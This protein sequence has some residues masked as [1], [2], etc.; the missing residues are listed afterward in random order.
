MGPTKGKPMRRKLLLLS[1]VILAGTSAP[2]LVSPAR[3]YF[4]D[5]DEL[6][7]H[8][9]TNIPDEQFDPAVCVTY[10]MGAY[11]AYM[12]QRLVRNQPRCT[13]RTLTAGQLRAVVVDYLEDNPDNRAMDA[14]ALVWN[15]IIAEWPECARA[16]AR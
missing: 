14:S 4:L 6:M 13:P 12:F 3:A 5:G 11:D 9:S 15:A 7:N 10:I 1:L 16:A 2:P 8:C